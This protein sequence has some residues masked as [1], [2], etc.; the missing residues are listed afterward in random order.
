[1]AGASSKI[2]L[3]VIFT[4]DSDLPQELKE[5]IHDDQAGAYLSGFLGAD[6]MFAAG[7]N[8][9]SGS[10]QAGGVQP[11]S[12]A[13]DF[14]DETEVID[15]PNEHQQQYPLYAAP[16]PDPPPFAMHSQPTY[17]RQPF[18]P[19]QLLQQQQQE[20]QYYMQMQPKPV[21]MY[22]PKVTEVSGN[23]EPVKFSEA[24]GTRYAIK[25]RER[26]PVKRARMENQFKVDHDDRQVLNAPFNGQV[27]EEEDEI[28][29][30]PET[31]KPTLDGSAEESSSLLIVQD[32]D[33]VDLDE[34]DEAIEQLE[35]GKRI[36]GFA[37]DPL[38][39]N[40]FFRNMALQELNWEDGIIWDENVAQEKLA[41]IKRASRVTNSSG[42]GTQELRSTTRAVQTGAGV[43][44]IDKFNISN[45]HEY[46]S[47]EA[48]QAATIRQ[49]IGPAVLQHSIPAVRLQY[50]YVKTTLSVKELRYFH[51]PQFFANIGETIH[52][53]RVK[54]KAKKMK[55]KEAV[56]PQSSTELTLKDGS[57]YVLLEYSEEYPPIMMNV[58]MGALIQNYYR[59]NDDRDT[60]VPDLAIGEPKLLEPSDRSP[61]ELFGQVEP[62]QT[63]Q[64]LYTDLVR[65]PIFPHK[66]CTTDFLL[67]RTRSWQD[68]M[69]GKTKYYI[70]ELPLTF[71]VG[72]LFPQAE[73]PKPRGRKLLNMVKNHMTIWM[74]RQVIKRRQKELETNYTQNLLNAF[75]GTAEAQLRQRFKGFAKFSKK[76]Q[77]GTY[78]LEASLPK[79][80]IDS[81]FLNP[82]NPNHI[83]LIEA[84]RAWAQ[85]LNDNN[86]SFSNKKG[87]DDDDGE[88]DEE[89]TTDLQI[90][91]APWNLTKTFRLAAQGKARVKLHGAGDPTGRGEGFSFVRTS[92]KEVFL[93]PGESLD[94]VQGRGVSKARPNA[95]YSVATENK[96]YNDFIKHVWET[97]TQSLS[98]VQEPELDDYHMQM[99][100]NK[101]TKSARKQW[102]AEEAD[103]RRQM[104]GGTSSSGRYS[105][106][107]SPAASWNLGNNGPMS[108]AAGSL[109][110]G[111][112]VA[113]GKTLFIKRR[114][115]DSYGQPTWKAE[116]VQDPQVIATYMR[117]RGSIPGDATPA[118]QRSLLSTIVDE[119][120][121]GGEVDADGVLLAQPRKH[122][123]SGA[124]VSKRRRGTIGD[125]DDFSPSARAS[126][127]RRRA[128]PQISF[129]KILENIIKALINKTSFYDFLQIP[130][131]PGYNTII[132]T[133]MTLEVMR[134]KISALKYKTIAQFQMDL[135]LIVH[136]S[137][138]YNGADHHVT[139]MAK[140]LRDE[141]KSLILRERQ[142]LFELEGEMAAE[143]AAY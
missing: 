44:R 38:V 131:I 86:L 25:P 8:T 22:P 109:D 98:S 40:R 4:Q 81:E 73:V 122:P 83:C 10:Q 21:R 95:K 23:H 89:E 33:I 127:P 134:D 71:V 19:Q 28:E 47:A 45:D 31:S 128:N 11:R 62:G 138:T 125:M 92:A 56:I 110:D 60:Y 123:D 80:K 58:G 69:L 107:A 93:R 129:H 51:R 82:I 57:D 12:D 5:S 135:E 20:Q 48:K 100:Y 42:A 13:V 14:Q 30:I 39:A 88:D 59:K 77:I 26:R 41:R 108:P 16:L 116:I 133:P 7:P 75:P 114:V 63:I 117:Y 29:V 37:V 9:A 79:D 121:G 97:Q 119:I 120:K 141:G 112:S 43:T 64:M 76:N 27:P 35:E 137:T 52:F 2:G 78:E 130:K 34:W 142:Q 54:N 126:Q 124:A 103:R 6:A 65:A 96:M 66:P 143:M 99:D 70:R 18:A 91:V 32:Y 118:D 15:D 106:A 36:V 3:S 72:Q 113:R 101:A 17:Q 53:S 67:I 104:G 139:G 68:S 87:D 46:S 24:F 1:M 94:Q 140:K 49:V 55:K 136:N 105:G 85:W 90:R 84:S 111:R 61:F 50:P 102:Q 132:H 115:R 74:Y